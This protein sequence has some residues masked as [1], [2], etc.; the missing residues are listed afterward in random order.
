VAAAEPT[1]PRPLVGEPR[2]RGSA[3]ATPPPAADATVDLGLDELAARADA[4][5]SGLHDRRSLQKLHELERDNQ[6]LRA[7]LDKARAGE[8]GAGQ[9]RSAASASS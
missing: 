8:R 2:R 7:E 6:R 5:Q 4:E 3:T 9:G 1:P